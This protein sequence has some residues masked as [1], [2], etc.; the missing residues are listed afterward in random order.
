[1]KKIIIAIDGYS[2]CG[3]STTARAVASQLGYIYIDSGAMYRAITYLLMKKGIPFTDIEAINKVLA[4]VK[5]NFEKD[6]EGCPITILNGE[7]VEKAIRE[8]DVSDNVSEVSAI[9]EI[10]RAMVKIQQK[11]GE[12]SGIVMD[13]RD[14]G[15]VVF[16]DAE[17]KVFMTADPKIRAERRMKE[18]EEKGV[19]TSFEAVLRNVE[20]RDRID[21]TRDDSPLM[22]A[23]D[24]IEIDNSYLSFDEQ[25]EKVLELANEQISD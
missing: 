19:D 8:K 16:P 6:D 2:A 13:G 12:E 22:Q 9:S 18:W 11:L 10:R 3:K 7:K 17:L 21:S 14:I 1:M 24:A 15:T 25:V 23:D 5:L 4:T 20:E